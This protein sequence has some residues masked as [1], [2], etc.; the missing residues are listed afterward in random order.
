MFDVKDNPRDAAF[1]QK[2]F[3]I[4]EDII[5]HGKYEGILTE[6][7][8]IPLLLDK[9]LELDNPLVK[10]LFTDILDKYY[11]KMRGKTIPSLLKK[12]SIKRNIFEFQEHKK[13]K[14]VVS[15]EELFG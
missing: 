12:E 7:E 6:N 9:T 15:V 14:H 3:A 5:L 4:S 10:E 8:L 13:I 2:A 11:F 1:L